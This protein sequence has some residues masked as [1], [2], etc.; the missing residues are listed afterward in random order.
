LKT[1]S[2]TLS[3]NGRTF[4]NTPIWAMAVIPVPPNNAL[5]MVLQSANPGIV[6]PATYELPASSF[7]PLGPNTM[8][9]TQYG[10]AGC[11]AGA[12]FPTS[13]TVSPA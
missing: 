13:I 5:T 11:D 6:A 8:P 7:N 1:V 2:C 9:R 3:L 10:N 12:G 4:Q